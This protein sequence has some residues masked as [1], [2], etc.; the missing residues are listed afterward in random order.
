MK[1]FSIF[2]AKEKKNEKSPDYNISL[3]VGEKYMN[4]GGCWLKDGKDGGKYFS[5]K[6]SDGYQGKYGFSLTED[7][8]EKPQ[9]EEREI[10]ADSIPL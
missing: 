6:L 5:C 9:V 8:L 3:K 1:N 4:V 2:K 10:D 7:K